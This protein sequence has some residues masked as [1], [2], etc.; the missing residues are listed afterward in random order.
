MPH[1]TCQKVSIVPTRDY[2]L[3]T[4]A[5]ALPNRAYQ[6]YD[7]SAA[8]SYGTYRHHKRR[9][10]VF[11]L[12]FLLSA[13]LALAYTWLRPAIY[14]S[15]ATL[16]FESAPA[17]D[18]NLVQQMAVQQRILTSQS[19][20]ANLLAQLDTATP[21]SL[22]ELRTMLTATNSR[23]S[24]LLELHAQGSQK[25]IL[26]LLI[27]RWIEVY[28]QAYINSQQ[29]ALATKNATLNQQLDELKLRVEEKRQ[30]VALFRDQNN[31]ISLARDEN[32]TA[33]RLSGLTDALNLA[34]ADLINA[35]ARLQ[36]ITT[37]AA[38]G[39]T[40]NLFAEDRVLA[41]LS[42]R[43]TQIDDYLKS[44]S[45][46]F[47]PAYM[48][49]DPNIVAM[50]RNRAR[51][52][53][54]IAQ[55]Q[56]SLQQTILTTA[57]QDVASAEQ[58]VNTLQQQLAE[59]QQT[60]KD[61]SNQFSNYNALQEELATLEARYRTVQDTLVQNE[62]IAQQQ[63]PSITVLDQARVATTPIY[64][65][66]WRDTAISLIAA[67]L[68]GLLVAL[69]V[70]FFARPAPTQPPVQP[71]PWP[72]PYP[73]ETMA[74]THRPAPTQ[75]VALPHQQSVQRTLNESEITSL[76]ANAD[77]T[78]RLLI[79]LLQQGMT[80]EEIAAL[81]WGAVDIE[82]QYLYVPGDNDRVL[83]LS[84]DLQSQLSGFTQHQP[85]ADV[86]LFFAATG[87]PLSVIELSTMITSLAIEANL[88]DAENITPQTLYTAS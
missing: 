60:A 72:V 27:E 66:Y 61:F 55:R 11:L 8:A 78:G 63:T 23:G 86:P 52:Q 22:D 58:A 1:L 79:T 24:N 6:A 34:S 82:Q 47:T 33:A 76:L 5:L 30:Q 85:K 10:G 71:V 62:V 16:M 31:I 39:Q 51:L 25:T 15:S 13:V 65:H 42:K 80:I 3:P 77:E 14:Q 57:Q 56:Q 9:L 37:A 81:R 68:L 41:D 12:I 87:R 64:P 67:L 28:R 54:Q 44:L 49:R 21:A 88:A 53:E 70:E 73:A 4:E 26:P 83:P 32:Q 46:R 43:I 2:P 59:F 7:L 19:V 38:A 50:T 35:K 40:S 29:T 17:N 36:A 69:I 45:E 84:R 75:P 18:T 48:K 20:L 74:I